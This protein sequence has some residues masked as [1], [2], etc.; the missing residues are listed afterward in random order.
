VFESLAL[1]RYRIA[2][3]RAPAE[4]GP[5]A[6]DI[7]LTWPG[8]VI[9]LELRLP[10]AKTIAGSV[11]DAAGEAV[12]DAWVEASLVEP[13]FPM[14]YPIAEPVLSN[15]DGH[16]ELADLPPGRYAISAVHASG[17]AQRADVAA[18][19]SGVRLVVEGYGSLSGTVAAADGQP[20]RDFS[21]FVLRET[22]GQPLSVDGAG[23]SWALP[24]VAPGAYRIVVMSSSGGVAT[25][26]RVSSGN[27]TK[28][29]LRLD[30]KL[31][32]GAVMGL[33]DRRR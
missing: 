28:L 14:P 9:E 2:L 27:D 7:E 4:P 30:P 26:A 20:A 24:W 17:E 18:G 31:S 12:P 8:Q 21:V 13:D 19:Q 6:V 11:V 10:E 5:S 29:T 23:G 1:G 22:P 25:D 15:A 16:F 3:G 33:L 32:G